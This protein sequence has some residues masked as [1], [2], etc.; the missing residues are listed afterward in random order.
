MNIIEIINKK[1]YKQELT[2]EE[3]RYFVQGY[4]DNKIKDYQISSLLMAIVLNGMNLDETTYLTKAI[5]DSGEVLDLSKIKGIKVDKHSTGGVGDKT[6]LVLLPLLASVGV[7]TAKLSGRGLGHTGGTIDKL[8]AIEGFNT[9]IKNEDF[10]NQVNKI[11]AAIAGQTGNLCPGDKKLYALRDVTG[12]VDSIPLIASS[13]MSKKIA[14]GSD[15]ILLDVKVGSGAFMKTLD[16]ARILAKT[17][18]EIGHRLN[19]KVICLLTNMDEPLGYAVGNNVEVEEAVNTLKGHG[20]K[21]LEEL[22]LDISKILATKAN[23]FKTEKDAYKI[24]KENLH[25]NKAYDKFLEIVKYQ[26]GNPNFKLNKPKHIIEVKS[27]NEGY[28]KHIDALE[29]GL[30]ACDLGAGRKTKEDK[31]DMEV[32]IVLNKKVGDYVKVDDV[33][34]YIYS[35]YDNNDLYI[36]NFL[37]TFTYSKEIIHPNLILDIIK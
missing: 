2:E 16:D 32:G 21:D 35:N 7:K 33:L 37:K 5:I 26:G 10:I 31:I 12:T 20:P 29:I 22:V 19:R 25:N 14:S 11:N 9:S 13:I 24:L 28:I 27:L 15:V 4:V 23:V 1:K 18:V 3:I 34:G 36:N 17:M 30:I 8:E 6:T